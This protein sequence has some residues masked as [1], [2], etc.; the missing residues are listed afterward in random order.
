MFGGLFLIIMISSVPFD[1]CY[2]QDPYDV[3]NLCCPPHLPLHPFTNL[4][5]IY[6]ASI[7]YLLLS[8]PSFSNTRHK[9]SFF[10]TYLCGFTFNQK[11]FPLPNRFDAIDSLTQYLPITRLY[12]FFCRLRSQPIGHGNL[13]FFVDDISYL[14]GQLGPFDPH[15]NVFRILQLNVLHF[16]IFESFM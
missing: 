12:L 13:R 7:L 4:Q 3:M 15:W 2:I 10:L 6:T 5:Q 14:Q 9:S 1:T 16:D 11:P 8:P